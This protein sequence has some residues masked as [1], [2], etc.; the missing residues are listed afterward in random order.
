[1]PLMFNTDNNVISQWQCHVPTAA[2]HP[3]AATHSNGIATDDVTLL[4][5]IHSNSKQEYHSQMII[6]ANLQQQC[7]PQCR[8]PTTCHSSMDSKNN[9]YSPRNHKRHNTTIAAHPMP[10]VP[11]ATIFNCVKLIS[12]YMVFTGEHYMIQF[13][14]GHFFLWMYKNI[15]WF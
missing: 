5:T 13:S 10:V 7:N 12:I 3:M 4:Y 14:P 8:Q 2:T 11:V 6:P 15:P 1:M 9:S